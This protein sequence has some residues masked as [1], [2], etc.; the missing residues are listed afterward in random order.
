MD[1]AHKVLILH[2]DNR[3]ISLL[4]QVQIN[5]QFTKLGILFGQTGFKQKL[6]TNWEIWYLNT[7]TPAHNK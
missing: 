1:F 7:I 4:N 5:N 2:E 3:Q 6:K